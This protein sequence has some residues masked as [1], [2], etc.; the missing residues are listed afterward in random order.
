MPAEG[1]T[2]P[3]DLEARVRAFVA[4]ETGV[5]EARVSGS[6]R[7]V[8]DLRI[9]GTDGVE[10]IDAFAD[11]FWVNMTGFDYSDFFGPEAAFNP[12]LY[13][14][15]WLTGQLPSLRTLTVNDLVEAARRGA[16]RT[17]ETE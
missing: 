5:G 12:F 9:D 17:S 15:W 8:Q 13:L 3:V 16:W 11:T 4:K 10:L 14:Y 1:T 6:T 7:L 2:T